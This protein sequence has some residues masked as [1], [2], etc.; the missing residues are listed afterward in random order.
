MDHHS[1]G[2]QPINP[3]DISDEEFLQIVQMFD[4]QESNTEEQSERPVSMEEVFG[5]G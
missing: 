5:N 2:E 3:Q 4:D 1:L